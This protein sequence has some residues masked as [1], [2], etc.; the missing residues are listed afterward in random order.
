M[1]PH[2]FKNNNYVQ[3]LI[4]NNDGDLK[5]ITHYHSEQKH[6]LKTA[7]ERSA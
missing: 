6:I 5:Y 1:R 3:D 4:D 2:Y 7:F